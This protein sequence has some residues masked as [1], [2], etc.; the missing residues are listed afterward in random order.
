[1]PSTILRFLRCCTGPL[2]L[3]LDGLDM[4][5]MAAATERRPSIDGFTPVAETLPRVRLP[6]NLEERRSLIAAIQVPGSN[7]G[8]ASRGVRRHRSGLGRA[9]GPL[10]AFSILA[11][12]SVV[13]GRTRRL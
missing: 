1:M 6:T 7:P 5:H 4:L 2:E 8:D 9:R 10:P 13:R 11:L 12:G 3:G